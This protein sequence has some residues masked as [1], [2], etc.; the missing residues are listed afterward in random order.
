ML[1]ILVLTKRQYT[2]KDLID[3]RFGRIREIPLELARK[4]HRLRGIC[5]S[6]R[7]R[8]AGIH[9][10]ESVLWHSCNLGTAIIP[11]L[12]GFTMTA[13]RTLKDSDVL[14]ACSDP[15][16]G[17]IGYMLARRLRKP[18]VF[19]LYDNFEYFL[20]GRMPVFKA[21]Y[22]HAVRSCAAVTV[23]SRP[24]AELVR[25]YGRMNR[26]FVLENGID[27]RVFRRWDPGHSR[28]KLKLPR[29]ATLVGTAGAL[30]R[31]RGIENL[32]KAFFILSSKHP[33]LHLAVAGPRD[34]PIPQDSRIHDL[35]RLDYQ[36]VPTFLSA[37]D[38]GVI[39]NLENEFGRYCFPQKAPEMM[40]CDV[41]IAA[42]AVGS[43]NDLFGDH[44]EW[45]FPPDNVHAMAKVI[46]RRLTDQR[47]GYGT[48]PAW[49]DMAARLETVL[50]E[51]C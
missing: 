19:D 7:H 41:P 8:S 34:I 29:N 14:W 22:R 44:P 23:A 46:E 40:A 18:M 10:D 9:Q 27:R 15:L 16:F 36:E 13:F 35:G 51:V 24:L 1:D 17:I 20:I 28:L 6:Y 30:Y 42:A 47:T 48:V 50:R 2:Q 32:F 25:T 33:D 31:N 37:L 5:L 26:I 11:G 45:L 49:S 21:L 38:V 43:L 39:C 12:A 4:G 3:D